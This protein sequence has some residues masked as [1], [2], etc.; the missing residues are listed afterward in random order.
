MSVEKYFPEEQQE[1][2]QFIARRASTNA[3]V[4]DVDREIWERFG[5]E[6]AIIFTD[7]AGFTS[8]S[9][10]FGVTH[11]LQ[12]IWQSQELLRPVIES[13]NGIVAKLVGDSMLV[14]FEDLDSAIRCAVAMQKSCREFNR[15]RAPQD[16]VLLC[17]GIGF[18]RMLRAGV[19]GMAGVEV[20]LGSKLGE[21]EAEAYE[22][23]VTQSAR[24]AAG[25]S[26]DV[27]FTLTGLEFP[28]SKEVY[29]IDY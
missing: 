2:W 9:A 27:E 24:E 19:S 8:R 4:E 25:D 18:G 6:G 21:D 16:Q 23:L 15:G 29:R 5:E 20:N 26:L 10:E 17:L 1:L 3:N 7:L 22:I 28:G 13:H 14:W 11:F 12:L